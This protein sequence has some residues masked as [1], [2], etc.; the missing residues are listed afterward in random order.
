MIIENV[1]LLHLHHD[2]LIL[3]EIWFHSTPLSPV[4]MVNPPST[5]RRP[6]ITL[7]DGHRIM[8]NQDDTFTV[9]RMNEGKPFM[10]PW[11]RLAE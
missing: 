1:P 9:D 4:L 11:T 8:V 5:G 6:S 10:S 2:D 7:Q 3:D